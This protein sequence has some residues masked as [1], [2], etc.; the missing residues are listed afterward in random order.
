MR[1]VGINKHKHM[2]I[3]VG[4]AH[5]IACLYISPPKVINLNQLNNVLWMYYAPDK[6]SLSNGGQYQTSQLCGPFRQYFWRGSFDSSP[7]WMPVRVR[8][9]GAA[10]VVGPSYVTKPGRQW[11]SNMVFDSD[12]S[13]GCELHLRLNSTESCILVNTLFSPLLFVN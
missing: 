1:V 13:K 8:D 4:F 7:F 3:V 2:N 11:V 9:V 5:T 10:G 6:Y 12:W